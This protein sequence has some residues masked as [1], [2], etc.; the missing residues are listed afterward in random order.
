MSFYEGFEK[1]AASLDWMMRRTIGGLK[2]RATPAGKKIAD[3]V[4]SKYDSLLESHPPSIKKTFQDVT[5]TRKA[6]QSNKNWQK[7]FRETYGQM[8]KQPK[9][10]DAFLKKLKKEY[11]E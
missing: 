7:E 5:A 8:K 2:S 1:R 6:T 9:K 11:E 4:R 10:A 3:K